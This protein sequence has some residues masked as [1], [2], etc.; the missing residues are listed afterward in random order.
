VTL[1]EI[2]TI[3]EA[4]YIVNQELDQFKSA[5]PRF[6]ESHYHEIAVLTTLLHALTLD[7][8]PGCKFFQPR[9]NREDHR[10]PYL[11]CQ[12]NL[13]PYHLWENRFPTETVACSM[14]KAK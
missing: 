8:C 7:P 3:P 2:L 4:I 9:Q 12:K 11:N 5:K 14:L 10:F 13:S 1:A 6:Q